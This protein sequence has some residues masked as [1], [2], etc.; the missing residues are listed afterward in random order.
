MLPWLLNELD[1]KP[2]VMNRIIDFSRFSRRRWM[3][4]LLL[5][6]ALTGGCSS[7]GGD[8]QSAVLQA[9]RL[10]Y[11]NEATTI[12]QAIQ[13]QA[14]QVQGTAVAAE[15]Y[16]AQ[17]DGINQ[18]LVATLRA[19]IPPTEQIASGGMGG[20][21]PQAILEGERWF[22][23]TGTS[24]SVRDSDGC[25]VDPTQSFGSDVSR[26][27]AT[28]EAHNIEAG[29]RLS[30][31]WSYE[32]RS[33]WT[34]GFNLERGSSF[35]CLWFFIDSSEVEMT[36]GTWSVQLFADGFKLESPMPFTIG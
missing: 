2:P 1:M 21:T 9:E 19:V 17:T 28:F 7:L 26:I 18:Q 25:V 27:Y 20:G 13:S 11:D 35:I 30:A 4:T 24:T 5:A 29:V 36:P 15:T 34:E 22:I 8:D 23:K 33:V 6:A 12:A 16:V 3:G 10:V 32:G 14:T 31:E